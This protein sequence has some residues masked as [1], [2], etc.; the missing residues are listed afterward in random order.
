MKFNTDDVLVKDVDVW[1]L[2]SCYRISRV[3]VLDELSCTKDVLKVVGTGQSC[4]L[5]IDVPPGLVTI[6]CEELLNLD[7]SE[8]FAVLVIWTALL[9]VFTTDVFPKET[10]SGRHH[11]SL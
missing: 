11:K 8:R 7:L 1:N 3:Q 4:E 2:L 5:V 6:L 10:G 9:T